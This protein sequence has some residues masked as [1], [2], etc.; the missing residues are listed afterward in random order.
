MKSTQGSLL[1]STYSSTLPL[2]EPTISP[3]V[4]R[5]LS[6][7][8]LMTAS[9]LAASCFGWNGLAVPTYA[10]FVVRSTAGVDQMPAPAN[11]SWVSGGWIVHVFLTRAPV[12]AS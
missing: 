3:N 5:V 8:I 10:Y 6:R 9:A 11:P 2:Y 7:S 1:W 4:G 12:A